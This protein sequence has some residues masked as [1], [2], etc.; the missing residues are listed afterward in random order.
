MSWWETLNKVDPD[1]LIKIVP[2]EKGGTGV[3]TLD[4]NYFDT[5]DDKLSLKINSISP[6][7]VNNNNTYYNNGNIGNVGIGTS[8]PTTKLEVIGDISANN[9][10]GSGFF[11]NNLNANNI[12]GI[13]PIEKG[14]TSVSTLDYNYFDT[15]NNK[16]SLKINSIS[17][18]SK[19]NNNYYYYNGNV[20]N[21]GIG[22]SIPT[23]KLE[24]I[25]DISA[26][27]YYGSGSNLTN[28]NANNIR[29]KVPIAR[30]GTGVSNLISGQLLVGN[31]TNP[32]LQTPNLFWDNS[33]NRLQIRG[34]ISANQI[35]VTGNISANNYYGSGSN[36]TNFNPNNINGIVPIEKG[37]T[38]V[39]TLD[40]NYFDTSNNKLSLKI[41]SISPW[42]K[43]NNN[44]YYNN[45]NVGIGTSIPTTKLEVVGDISA[46][47]Y[48]GSGS[49]LTNLN[50]SNINGTLPITRG[51]T[52]VSTLFNGQILVGNET[53]GLRQTPNLFW[54]NNFNRLQVIGD[55]SANRIN[56][57]GDI[58]ANNFY[59]SG[60]NLT[61]LNLSNINGTLPINKGGTGAITLANGQIL[62]GNGSNLMLQTPNLSWDNSLNRLQVTG[63]IS[64]NFY[65]SGSNLTNFN[66]NNINGTV[67][68]TKGGTGLTSLTPGQILVGNA[69]NTNVLLQ[70][71]NLFWNN[72]TTPNRLQVTGDI[73]ANKIIVTGDIS[74][75]NNFCLNDKCINSATLS[76]LIDFATYIDSIQPVTDFF[77]KGM[78][79]SGNTATLPALVA[80]QAQ[81]SSNAIVYSLPAGK[82][83]TISKGFAVGGATPATAIPND[84]LLF[85][86]PPV[87]ANRITAK[88]RFGIREINGI[89]KYA[90][91]YSPSITN[92]PIIAELTVRDTDNPEVRVY[93]INPF[94]NNQSLSVAV[95]ERERL[96]NNV[97]T[98]VVV[99]TRIITNITQINYST[100]DTAFKT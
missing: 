81:T 48:Y 31:E 18:W 96:V 91:I 26:N 70:T 73:S 13:V 51:G 45:G 88:F 78:V 30:G 6:W 79:G 69:T 61:N 53:N 17:P 50:L 52:G 42:S 35:N 80:Q 85:V 86:Y 60:S 8:L 93:F 64:A 66:P 82:Y 98:W 33:L 38:G 90:K 27:N 34:D 28:L 59:G 23:T 4:Y 74:G 11:L 76:N 100:T 29:D 20:G 83:Y 46:N 25:G 24:V 19:N 41:N 49:N 77:I 7:S 43:N 75:N 62:I 54:D 67:P 10:Y 72:T 36:L 16:L 97:A 39:S 99:D 1:D 5:S 55:I 94:I 40:Y 12:N 3:T 68:I 87:V 95:L 57:T 47:N 65:G 63:D 89:T 14:G 71:P 37:G 21:I 9:Y 15:S 2:I 84:T 56:V 58:S 44:Y 32:I 22:T 92:T